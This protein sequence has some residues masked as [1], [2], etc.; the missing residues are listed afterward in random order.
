MAHG[1]RKI[2]LVLGLLLTAVSSLEAM[3]GEATV[4]VAANFTGTLQ[5]LQKDFEAAG[6]H[7]LTIIS[8]ATGKLTAQIIEGAP[9]DVFLSADHKATKKLLEGGL[10]VADTEFTYAI[11]TLVLFSADPQL[12]K[13]DGQRVLQAGKFIKLAVPNPKLAP[14]GVAAVT[15]MQ[16]LGV[17]NALKEKI[18]MGENIAQTFQMIDTGNAQLGFVALSQLRGTPSGTRGSFWTVPQN[19]HEPIRQN[20]VLL[21]RARDNDAA[22]AFLE[23]LQGAQAKELIEAAGYSTVDG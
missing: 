21:T 7:K 10:A 23:F 17:A 4:A 20:A 6:D 12:I 5:K 2:A 8:G 16:M 22:R 11:G 18:V 13:G 19:L 3:A 1:M 14:Y 15:A 9:F